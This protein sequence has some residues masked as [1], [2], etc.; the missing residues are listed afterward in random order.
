MDGTKPFRF[1]ALAVPRDR[2]SWLDT[3]GRASDLGYRTLLM[4]D[5]PRLPAALP[6]LA[7]A[8][9]AADIGIGTWV[10]AAPLRAPSLVA[11]EARTLALL[12]GGR[13]EL[14]LGTGRPGLAEWADAAGLPYGSPAARLAAVVET[15]DRVRG[16]DGPHP[17]ILIAGGGDRAL[18]LAAEQAD[19]VTLAV[20]PLT[21]R[22]EVVR[23][24]T[25]LRARAGARADQIE[26]AANL[27]VVGDE[28]SAAA[29]GRI[30]ADLAA[31]R[32]AESLAHLSGTPQQMADELA[33]RRDRFGMSYVVVNAEYL[34]AL[35]PV[36]ELLADS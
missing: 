9:G 11:W 13:F 24:L 6:S 5:V 14:G 12:T 26:L 21:P 7:L 23:R 31:L 3:A 28:L 4:P 2:A 19:I 1:G 27:F 17:P 22:A 33:R 36:I 29:A 30:G 20:G 8:A 34:E 32:A 16:G 15:I 25:E 35:A 18:A 10:L